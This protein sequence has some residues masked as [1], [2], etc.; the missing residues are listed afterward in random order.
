METLPGT[1]EPLLVILSVIVAITSSF[2]ALATV[3]RIH[4]FSN[5]RWDSLW[6]VVFGLSLGAGIWSMHFIGMTAFHLPVPIFY[7]LPMTLFSLLLAVVVC[8]IAVLPLRKGGEI[9]RI[10]ILYMGMLVGFG[11]AGMHY[12]GMAAM[13]MNADMRFS[14][15]VV[16]LSIVIAIVAASAAL[17]IAN[18]LR[19]SKVFSQMKLKV[20]AAVVMGL[21]V[22]SMHYTAMAGMDFFAGKSSHDLSQ[23]IDPHFLAFSVILIALL[24]QGGTLLVAL[25]E[26]AYFSAK[27]SERSARERSEIDQTLFSILAVAIVHRPLNEIL[28][29]ILRLLLDVDWL[30]FEK[31]GAIF[32]TDPESKTLKMV[33]HK[34]LNPALLKACNN[35]GF[36]TCLCGLAAESKKIVH[37]DCVDDDHTIQPSGMAAHGH[38][39]L[40]VM[41][42]QE[43]VL[44]VINLY[45]E[46]GHKTSELELKFLESVANVV[47]GIIE[48]ANIDEKL[49]RMSFEDELT[50]L[51]NRRKF[52]ETFEHAI[53]V[54][55]RAEGNLAVMMLDLDRFKPVNDT[56]G[57]DVGDILLQQVAKRVKGCLRDMDTCA[58][59]GGDE[60]IILLEMIDIPGTVE[61]IGERLLAELKRPFDINGHQIEIG[62]SIGVAIYPDDAETV[63]ELTKQ[64]DIALYKAKERRGSMQL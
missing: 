7:D 28:D 48:R 22:S 27:A 29:Q 37:R 45:L 5:S 26:E 21:A 63:D 35:I 46:H 11:V 12:V 43:R 50:G 16:V 15:P 49:K 54:A 55:K 56:F 1:H 24:I 44:G 51:P 23:Y 41:D 32:V 59:V 42:D 34:N 39:C 10:R 25:L 33:A 8:S 60:F 18:H 6:S 57:H 64:A 36:G 2:V 58:R 62:G 40:P 9:G 30:S 13:R 61:K 20:A 31:K 52:A 47:A 4:C 19:D 53:S 17:F 38:Y 3:P 14:L